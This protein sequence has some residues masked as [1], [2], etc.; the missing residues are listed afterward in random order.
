MNSFI[1]HD[2]ALG[3]VLLS[4][5]A[6]RS[7]KREG[8]RLH[9]AGRGDVVAFLREAGA[10]DEAS[11]S[12]SGRY[13][14]LY[15]GNVA[16]RTR[17]FL[18]G[19]SRAVIFTVRPDSVLVAAVRSVISDTRVVITVPP[20]GVAVPLAHFR[21]S[22][23]APGEYVGSG[24]F[25]A[26]P[27]PDRDLAADT[28][29]RAGY[30]GSR[31]LIAIHPGSSGR[32]KCWPLGN[33]LE[34]I[35]RLQEGM[36]AFVIILTGPAEDASFRDRIVAFTR[37]RP[38]VVAVADAPLTT[39]AA[40]LGLSH[41]FIGND[42][43]IGHLAAMLGSSVLI[44]FGPTDPALWRPVGQ[45]VTAIHAALLAELRVDEVSARVADVLSHTDLTAPKFH[46]AESKL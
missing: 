8:N 41:L 23:L 39:V 37:G 44:L 21:L 29:S 19:F 27:Q 13:A 24:P 26:V 2:G 9:L 20:E 42:S 1:H 15:T 5:P 3:D 11:S 4:L 30:D 6:I 33:Y 45:Q 34:L 17:T 31:P 7:L 14:S 46:G 28:L 18:S 43:G 32:A 40:L 10:V 22:Q 12:D 35:A 16:D 38:G 36:G 25:L